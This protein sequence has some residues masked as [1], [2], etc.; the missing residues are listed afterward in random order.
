MR[1]A[2]QISDLSGTPSAETLSSAPGERGGTPYDGLCGK[3]P[4][5]RGTFFSLQV[6]ERVGVSPVE[7]YQIKGKEICHLDL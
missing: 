4:T 7:V 3:A 1:Y 2:I 5:E 6:Y